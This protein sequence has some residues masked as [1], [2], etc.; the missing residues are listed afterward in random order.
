MLI[1]CRHCECL[2]E[3]KSYHRD[4]PILECGHVKV[5]AK[6]DEIIQ[7]T[8]QKIKKELSKLAERKG[9]TFEELERRFLAHLSQKYR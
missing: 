3:V 8:T 6:G 2:Q 4:E 9:I 7:E 1:Y 5:R